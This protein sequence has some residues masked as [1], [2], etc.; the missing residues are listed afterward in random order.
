MAALVEGVLVWISSFLRPLSSYHAGTFLSNL[1]TVKIPSSQNYFSVCS[2]IKR[3][4]AE[5]HSM[6]TSVWKTRKVPSLLKWRSG[7][8]PISFPSPMCWKPTEE[9]ILGDIQT[10]LSKHLSPIKKKKKKEPVFLE[11][12]LSWDRERRNRKC[13]WILV[14]E[15]QT[16]T[17]ISLEE[18]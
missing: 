7:Y 11:S 3:F 12:C 9:M 1:Q 13:T 15:G 4:Q 14:G 17:G 5:T 6:A 18:F 8:K 2:W 10:L 16:A